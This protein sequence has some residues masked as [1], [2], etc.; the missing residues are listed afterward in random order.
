LSP[1]SPVPVAN[2][3]A[4]GAALAGFEPAIPFAEEFNRS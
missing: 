1:L 4:L 3:D 2:A